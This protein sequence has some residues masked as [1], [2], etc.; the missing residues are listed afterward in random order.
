[1]STILSLQS[2]GDRAKARQSWL[3]HALRIAGELFRKAMGGLPSGASGHG[4]R[5]AVSKSLK[6]RRSGACEK[7]E[8]MRGDIKM[9][10]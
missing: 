3:S 2:P 4:L 6:P 7:A 10:F 5:F 1:M 9:T 8:E